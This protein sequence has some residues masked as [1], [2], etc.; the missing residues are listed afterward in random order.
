MKP[1]APKFVRCA[2]LVDGMGCFYAV[3]GAAVLGLTRIH[4]EGKFGKKS[5]LYASFYLTW[6]ACRWGFEYTVAEAGKPGLET[7]A[8][9]GA[10]LGPTLGL[11]G[12]VFKFYL[13]DSADARR[14]D[15]ATPTTETT[16][17]A[18]TTG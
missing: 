2:A 13:G 6:V 11:T 10:I 15:A 9:I 7:A 14:V 8:V 5:M 3:V 4:D 18:K 16:L 1:V 12:F 17:V